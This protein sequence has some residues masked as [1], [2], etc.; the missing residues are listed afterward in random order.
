[1]KI[2]VEEINELRRLLTNYNDGRVKTEDLNAQISIY[3]QTNR[4]VQNLLKFVALLQKAGM[5][6]EARR[7]LKGN[8]VD[9]EVQ[10]RIE[11]Y[12]RTKDRGKK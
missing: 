12:D 5:K 2:V 7:I 8:K 4:R 11:M 1:M 10:P 9:I 6:S 3:K